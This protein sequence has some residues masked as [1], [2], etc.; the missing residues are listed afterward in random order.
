MHVFNAVTGQTLPIMGSE[1]LL[2]MS[3]ARLKTVVSMQ[4]GLPVSSFRLSTPAGVQLYDCNQLKDYSIEV[5]M[6]CFLSV[7]CNVIAQS[8]VAQYDY[9]K[10]CEWSNKIITDSVK[11]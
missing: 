5:G 4:S 3:V 6:A 9:V 11:D 7:L 2:Q 10:K 8:C 1:A